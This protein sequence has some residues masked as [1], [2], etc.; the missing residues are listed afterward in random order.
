MIFQGYIFEL[1]TEAFET[2]LR[3]VYAMSE[4]TDLELEPSERVSSNSTLETIK[5]ITAG[6]AGGAA[7]VMIGKSF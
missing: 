5:D 4:P 7:Q 1:D 6:A 3:P 2:N